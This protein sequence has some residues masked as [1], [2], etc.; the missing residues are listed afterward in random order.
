[1]P[2]LR[3]LAPCAERV[4]VDHH[5]RPARAGQLAGGGQP[6]VAGPDDGD[7]DRRADGVG[8]EVGG[9]AWACHSTRSA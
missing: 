1:M 9:S 3:V 8:R 7:V 4:A 6:A 5:H 2:P